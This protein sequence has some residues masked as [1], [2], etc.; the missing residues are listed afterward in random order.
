MNPL[1][2][3]SYTIFIA[4]SLGTAIWMV[5]KYQ[6][7]L[8][9]T[10]LAGLLVG[11]SVMMLAQV[12]LFTTHQLSTAIL[13]DRLGFFGGV[14]TY[15]MILMFCLYFPFPSKQMIKNSALLWIVPNVFFIPYIFLNSSFLTH[16]NFITGGIQE[17]Y[18]K[19]F[20]LFPIIII[21]YFISSVIVLLI[22]APSAKGVMRGSLLLFVVTLFIVA[23]LAGYFDVIRPATGHP[24]IP[25]GG[26]YALLLFGVSAYTLAKR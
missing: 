9:T 24:R 12:V 26:I 10:Y 5:G 1:L 7:A 4:V 2:I 21:L 3:I 17:T 6:R 19:S 23:G 15:S 25:I 22:K 14:W 18:G 20:W 16:I 13:F 8:S 11:L